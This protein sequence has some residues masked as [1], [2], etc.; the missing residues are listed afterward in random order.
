[1]SPFATHRHTPKDWD[2]VRMAFSSSILVDTSLTSLAQNLEGVDWPLSGRDET[3]A[4]YIDLSF[5]EMRERLALRGQPPRVADQLIDILKETLAFDNPFGDMVVQSEAAAA[6]ENPLMKNLEK[7]KI[8][9]AFP[10]ALTSLAPE[11]LLFCRLENITT[12]GEFALAAQR[13]AGS[14]IVGG[15]FR[16]LLNALSNIDE[17]TLARYLPFRQGATGV[18]YIEGLAQGVGAQPVAIQ[19]ALARELKQTLPEAAEEMART[20]P[21][22]QLARA[23][24]ELHLHAGVLR[25]FCE[26][27]HADLQRQI[28]GGVDPRRLV[29]VLGDPVTEAVVADLITPPPVVAPAPTG[30]VARLLRWWRN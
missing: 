12:L 11:T 14:V 21:Q 13:M 23:R 29:A 24:R 6:G 8:P 2:D 25:G 17:A 16:A 19:A 5:D 10:I 15:D 9:P 18:H 1:M 30:L 4:A 27:E 22:E 26:A 3:P 7:L 20:V 28:A